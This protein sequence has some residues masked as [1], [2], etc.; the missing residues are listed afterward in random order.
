MLRSIFSLI[1]NIID[2]DREYNNRK[3]N[4]VI[5]LKSTPDNNFNM[6]LEIDGQPRENMKKIR[7]SEDASSF[8]ITTEQGDSVTCKHETDKIITPKVSAKEDKKL[9]EEYK[10][11]VVRIGGRASFS[12]NDESTVGDRVE[13]GLKKTERASE[14]TVHELLAQLP[15][16]QA[17]VLQKDKDQITALM[18]QIQKMKIGMERLQEI[19]QQFNASD[20][21]KKDVEFL[22]KKCTHLFKKSR[23]SGSKFREAKITL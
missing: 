9:C 14:P 2:S 7:T 21:F 4:T 20:Q 1:Q 6:D 17:K 23:S 15:Q 12:N 10:E 8:K 19:A 16:P 13:D 11:K 5:Y 22:T 3:S 18:E